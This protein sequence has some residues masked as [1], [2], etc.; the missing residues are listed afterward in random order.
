MMEDLIVFLVIAAIVIAVVVYIIL[1]LSVFILAS[2][3]IVGAVSGLGVATKNF[4][5]L[6]IE[7]HKTVV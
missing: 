5:E 3:S 7:A 2:V 6:L 1:P 4:G